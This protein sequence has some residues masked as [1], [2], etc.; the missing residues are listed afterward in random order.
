MRGSAALAL[1]LL[2]AGPAVPAMAGDMASL[3]VLG[4]SRDGRV[5][6]F[7]E[8]GILDGSGGA[9]S[10]I[11][12]V[13][14]GADRFLPGTPIR[15]VEH[16][17]G[18]LAAMRAQARATAAALIEEH[19]L[20][21]N[22]GILVAYNPPSEIGGNAHRV[23]YYPSLSAQISGY[24]YTLE[25]EEKAFPPT[26]DCLNMT[27]SYTGFALKLTEHQGRPSDRVLHADSAIPRSRGCPNQY[28]IGA[29]VSSEIA[30]VPQMAM[31]LVGSFGFEGND[32]R[33][34]AVPILPYGP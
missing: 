22:P 31:I 16:E 15:A 28:R 25:L 21:D 8:Y 27:G 33:W 2:A 11:Y 10:S 34:I 3:D 32:Q 18:K 17:G 4:Y 24:T 7:E 20:A 6:A 9:Y 26:G 30:D 14:I 12:F 1:G 13:D 29:V 19:G 23:R 5:F